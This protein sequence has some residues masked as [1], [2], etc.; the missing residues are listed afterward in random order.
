MPKK[1]SRAQET[2]SKSRK[3]FSIRTREDPEETVPNKMPL[4]DHKYKY[5]GTEAL[6]TIGTREGE[7]ERFSSCKNL[8]FF[9]SIAL[10]HKR[11]GARA[12]CSPVLLV[13]DSNAILYKL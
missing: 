3:K 8:L 11:V 13:L 4:K 9:C 10:V 1:K 2:N 7:R 5:N 6:L 12:S